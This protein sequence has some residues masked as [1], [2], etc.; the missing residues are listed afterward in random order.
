MEVTGQNVGRDWRREGDTVIV[1]L[2][3][4]VLG[5]GTVLVTFEQPMSA[6]GGDLSPGEVRPLN[7][8]SERGYIQVVSP[9]QVKFAILV[10]KA[11]C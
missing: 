11:R 8:Q 9:L 6:R 7:V 3:R 5:A 2:A 1:P 4:P 10:A